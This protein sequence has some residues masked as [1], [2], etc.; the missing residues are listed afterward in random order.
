MNVGYELSYT[1]NAN[2]SQQISNIADASYRADRGTNGQYALGR[3]TGDEQTGKT[4]VYGYDA[5]GNLLYVNKGRG[6]ADSLLVSSTRRLLWDEENRLLALSDNGYVSNYW[7]DAAG[8]RTVKQSGGSEGVQVNGMTSAARTETTKFT[9]YIS[10]YMVVSNGGNYSKHIYMGSQRITSKLS[11]SGI[12]PTSPVKDT[13]Q[14]RY[15]L[16]TIKIKERFDSLGVKYSGVQQTGG[17]ESTDLTPP[18]GSWGAYFYHPDHLGSSSLITDGTGHTVQN[19]QYIPFGEVFVEERNASWSTPYKFNGKEQDE[20][21]GLC[22]YGARYYDP[23]TSSFINPDRFKEKYPNFNSYHY[24]AGNPV[25]Y[26]DVNGDTT[27]LYVTTLPNGNDNKGRLEK[28]P[29]H[30]FISVEL[31]N[32][33]KKHFAYGPAGNDFLGGDQM[34]E[35]DYTQDEEIM[36][37]ENLQNLK[38][39]F[40]ITPPDGMSVEEFD[41]KVIKMAESFGNNKDIR[42]NAL[43]SNPTTG[44]CN[45]SSGTIL[46]KSGV[47]MERIQEIKNEMG[48]WISSGAYGFGTIRPWTASEQKK[49]VEKEALKMKAYSSPMIAR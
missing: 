45:T 14:A 1:I 31:K 39:V 49:A 30:T 35:S 9:A 34:I 46:L 41:N 4:E 47:S 24:C 6:R 11:N 43:T 3:Q 48:F 40:V 26:I 17:L 32:G 5:N 16:Q 20:E 23:R 36:K 15:A 42:Y 29:T 8:E 12:F 25:K 21:T 27:K 19:I 22:Y 44:N 7:Y 13:L 10:P 37:G 33:E 2:N 28:L 38:K 18:S